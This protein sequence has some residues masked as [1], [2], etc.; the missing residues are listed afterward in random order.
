MARVLTEEQKQ[1]MADGRKAAKE[2][3]LAIVEKQ[4]QDLASQV[5]A[6]VLSALKEAGVFG[7]KPNGHP[8][9]YETPALAPREP[10]PPP[11]PAIDESIKRV[12]DVLKKIKPSDYD[13]ETVSFLLIA[14][15]ELEAK[16]SE[17][18]ATARQPVSSYRCAI[19]RGMVNPERPAG[20]RVIT[21]PRTGQQ[22]NVW[23]DK[24]AC[25]LMWDSGQRTPKAE[26][27]GPR[28]DLEP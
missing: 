13:Y 16:C 6:N 15:R 7:K 3:K 20:N 27:M 23:F 4:S 21:N 26:T 17:F 28:I 12:V 10:P 1:K 11:E 24:Q 25:V 14:L 19:C 9:D 8:I 2:R 5:T 18:M 22:E